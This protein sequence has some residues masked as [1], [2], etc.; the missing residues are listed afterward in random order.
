M[1]IPTGS[2][3]EG[4]RSA[5]FNGVSDQTLSLITGVRHHLYTV[6][7]IVI[8]NAKTSASSSSAYIYLLGY[9]VRQSS[10]QQTIQLFHIPAMAENATFVWND[11]FS[12]YGCEN[13]VAQS[14]TT[15]QK[16]NITG[17]GTYDLFDITVSYIDQDFS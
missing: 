7:S 2:G 5:L 13:D 12:F 14:T 9:D 17:G 16:L 10:S 1:A 3:T 6:L 11:K 8:H 15:S 4:L